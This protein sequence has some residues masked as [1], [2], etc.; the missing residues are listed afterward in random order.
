MYSKLKDYNSEG[1]VIEKNNTEI[2]VSWSNIYNFS[3]SAGTKHKLLKAISIGLLLLGI[4]MIVLIIIS[5]L[6]KVNPDRRFNTAPMVIVFFMGGFLPFFASYYMWSKGVKPFK[7]FFKNNNHVI[8][9]HL[10]D[11]VNETIYA[12]TEIETISHFE[13]MKKLYQ[14]SKL[15]R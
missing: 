4:I 13:E 15:K 8:I 10:N 1:V 5:E 6:N 3:T 14:V 9:L 12:G 7:D 11:N 2:I